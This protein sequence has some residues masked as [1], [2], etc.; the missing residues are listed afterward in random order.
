MKIYILKVQ[1]RIA[2][3]NVVNAELDDFTRRREALLQWI[4]DL[5][6]TISDIKQRKARLRPEAAQHDI[7]Q[8]CIIRINLILSVLIMIECIARRYQANNLREARIG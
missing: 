1:T 6:N 2:G 7:N 5:R 4:A 8:V 3:L